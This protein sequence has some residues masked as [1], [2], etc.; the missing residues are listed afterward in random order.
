[1][2]PV[3]R[4]LPLPFSIALCLPALAA[5]EKPESWALCPIQ[6]PVPAFAGVPQ[7]AAGA[8]TEQARAARANQDTHIEGNELG[9]T[10]QNLEYKGDV[11]LVRGDQFLGADNLTYDQESDTY[12]AEGHVRYQDAGIRLVAESA[13]GDQ[14]ADRHQIDNLQY[15]LVSRRG[16]GGAD[17]IDMKGPEGSL[18]HSTYSTC[19]PSDRRW[20]LR[21]RR[22][23][24]NTETGWGVAHGATVRLG[25]VPVLYMPWFKF[26]IDDQRHT[27]LLYPALSHSGR[28]GFDYRQPI[29]LNL[30]PNYDA[31]LNPRYMSERGFAL[32]AEFRYLYRGGAGKLEGNYMHRDDLLETRS[33]EPEFVPERNPDPD[34]SR[35]LFRFNGYHNLGKHWQ[36]RANL[37]WIS[38]SRYVEDFAN[39]LG[40][41]TA[42]TLTST[43]GLYGVGQ[44]WNG[45]IM[46]D[47][48]QLSDFNLT[49]ASLP[50]N[51]LPRA[52]FNYERPLGQWLNIGLR[53][54]AVRFQHDLHD[55]GTRLDLKP[56][57]GLNFEGPSWY[58]RPTLAWRYTDYRLDPG[59]ARSIA[60]TR[61]ARALGV[62]AGSVTDAMMRPYYDESPNR[63]LP[64]GSVDMG[65]FFDRE[66][67]IKGS[68]FLQTLEPRLFYL[69]V[70]YR[71]QDG[72]PLFDTRPFT[73]SWGQMF[74]DNRYSGPDRQSD[75]NQLTMALTT[76]FLRQSDGFERASMSL[77]QI[78]YFEDSQVTL[79]PSEAPLLKGKSAWIADANY[80]PTDRWTIGASYQWDPKFRREDLASLRA[81]YLI[82]DDGVVNLT[83][84]HRR[85]LLEQGDFSFL[86]PVSPSWSIVGRYYHS[87]MDNK[88]LEGI[89]GIQWD[90]CCLAVRAV[91]RRY[92]RN[93]EGEM[94][95]S[96]QV[97]F[98]LKGL[99]SAGQDTERTLRRGILGYYRDDLYLVPPS[100][101]APDPDDDNRYAPDMLP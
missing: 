4:L 79:S 78:R 56:T 24:V 71:E 101:T 95:N 39:N 61:A 63:S 9:G 6:D 14:N 22:I 75:A 91:V 28:N 19:D 89:A 30:A 49:K 52:Y 26:P 51:R 7:P 87:F 99:G 38:D 54:E 77:G 34:D 11:A 25:H 8:N 96:I 27:G 23:D 82:G 41:L 58:I 60:V 76:R 1:M 46:A 43:A 84:R 18:L 37:V 85:D 90:S 32:G 97:E 21:S 72:I 50:Y 93:R 17:R 65:L 74:R 59:L 31:T 29:Y 69:N 45:G 86:Y 64:I 40:G 15:Q 62:P 12:S 88:L 33:H 44:F 94:N 80:A 16:N 3:L 10:E 73:F 68:R 70:P 35:G 67:E 55:G 53:S 83:Y 2:R 81:R 57:V 20:E 47:A 66:T 5:D 13:R 48:W 98:V 36:A 100:N 42:S 92:V